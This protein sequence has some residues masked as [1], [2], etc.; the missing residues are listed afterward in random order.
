MAI[1]VLALALLLLLLVPGAVSGTIVGD[2][3]PAS[4]DWHV[5]SDTTVT[6]ETVT[7]DGNLILEAQLTMQESTI[8]FN[9][10]SPGSIGINVTGSGVL[11]ARNTTLR[12][13]T[14]IPYSFIVNGGLLLADSTVEDTYLGIQVRTGEKVHIYNVLITDIYGTALLLDT[15]GADVRNLRVYDD[16]FT[17]RETW[18]IVTGTSDGFAELSEILPGLI[19]VL[20]G[21][22]WFDGVDVSL[23]GTLDYYVQFVQNAPVGGLDIDLEWPVF[24]VDSRDQTRLSDVWFRESHID[25]YCQVTQSQSGARETSVDLVFGVSTVLLDDYRDVYIQGLVTRTV[26]SHYITMNVTSAGSGASNSS[27]D[28]GNRAVHAY[29]D[30]VLSTPGPHRFKLVIEDVSLDADA[31]L[32]HRLEPGY[33]GTLAPTFQLHLQVENVTV[34]GATRPVVLVLDPAFTS[35]KTFDLDI[36]FVD[37]SFETMEGPAIDF[38]Y[39]TGLSSGSRSIDVRE[40]SVIE[41]CTFKKVVGGNHGVI[42]VS[43]EIWSP[44]SIMG[45]LT[46]TNGTFLNNSGALLNINGSS[47]HPRDRLVVR[48]NLFE[49]NVGYSGQRLGFVTARSEV[50][51][52][53]NSFID[54]TGTYG[55]LLHDLGA[56]V[57][58]PPESEYMWDPCELNISDNL[59]LR[60]TVF[61]EHVPPRAFIDVVWGG[62]LNVSGNHIEAMG[63]HF[64]NLSDYSNHSR[65]SVF[66]F[67]GNN[68]TDNDQIV[69]YFT[70]NDRYHQFLDVSIRE[71]LVWDNQGRLVD[72]LYEPLFIEYNEFGAT[73]H[74]LDNVVRGSRSTVFNAYGNI[75]VSGNTFTDCAGWVLHLE[76]LREHQPYLTNNTFLRCGD[77]ILIEAKRLAPFPTLLWMDDNVIDSNGT[78]LHFV[79]MEVTL[80]NITVTGSPFRAVV[81]EISYVDAYNCDF[82]RD[83]CEVVVDGY[84]N[85][86]YW[87]EAWIRWASMSGVATSNPVVDGNVTF[88][89]QAGTPSLTVYS[90]EEGHVDPVG[91]LA[92]HIEHSTA[93]IEKNP[94]TIV[95]SL[96]SFRNSY[97]LTINRSFK[98]EGALELLLWDPVGPFVS[99]DAP[100]DD[101]ALSVLDLEVLGFA[102][103]TGSG[104]HTLMV[105]L[106]DGTPEMATPGIDGSY[107]HVLEDVPEGRHDVVVTVADAGGNNMMVS[108]TVDVDRTAPRLV[109]THP[110]GDLYTN[111]STVNIKGEVEA[112][113]ELTLNMLDYTTPTGLFDITL[114][115][116]EGPNYFSLA[117]SDKAGNTASVVIWVTRDS[118]DPVLELYGPVDGLAVNHS[119]IKVWGLAEEYDSLTITLHRSFTDI[120]DRPI[121][122]GEDGRFE[123][124]AEI[125]EGENEIV[126]TASD[127]AGNT[128][129]F[130]RTVTLDMTPPSLELLSP[131]DGTLLNVRQVT[132]EFSVSDDAEQVYVNGKRVLGTG[133]LDAVVMLGEGENPITLLAIDRLNNQISTSVIVHVDTVAPILLLTQPAASYFKTNDPA[134]EVRGS[135]RDGDLNGITV[136]VDGVPATVTTDGKF[137]YLMNLEED[138]AHLIDV[139]ARDRAGNTALTS[140]TVDLVTVAPLVS[141]HFVP[142]GDRLDPGTVLLI[143]GASTRIP[144]NVT[145]VHDAAGE[146][147]SFS[148]L[149]INAS[150][151]HYLNLVKGVN[152]V[153]VRSVDEYG[154]TNVTAPYVVDVREEQEQEPSDSDALYLISAVVVATALIVVSY[155]ILRRP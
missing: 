91:V 146:E 34:L 131:Q 97:E 142:A 54:N 10:S 118:H 107:L 100:V 70:E 106:R 78:A 26:S 122:P 115:L 153:T 143:Q 52:V 77:A 87:V 130:R 104:V 135:T 67:V 132:V 12:S 51:M 47:S 102:T 17:F 111:G 68:V 28:R 66:N 98:D 13:S 148:F 101:S 110:K 56:W 5:Q 24:Q 63:S 103:D 145:I 136:T 4:G 9:V 93:P 150:F 139:V 14:D 2:Q 19:V 120:I 127:L 126:V 79:Y 129:T 82:E 40:R 140:F 95:V 45:D 116:S 57:T 152:T 53:D 89:D 27:E 35:F 72:Y 137:Y 33:S 25:L 134:I 61:E 44:D 109:V 133:Q 75:T 60:N 83:D 16:G 39:L 125:E 59:F 36:M 112:G 20:G 43:A 48:G 37:C 144:L 117:A 64:L 80:G 147:H 99:I 23:N 65:D 15:D 18:T 84:L 73:F 119:D 46:V 114:P 7:I 30:E 138:G 96:S 113:A 149:M 55:I 94:Y 31:L 62:V 58:E 42:R 1:I 86:W 32:L 50:E 29:V 3:P 74:L 11:D 141:L 105:G 154:N 6:D 88:K 85:M 124:Q 38:S 21:T 81:A 121:F 69:L 41:G 151:E 22:T 49:G 155:I 92:W 108:V 71:N 123:V 90:D 76:K 8:G 128:V